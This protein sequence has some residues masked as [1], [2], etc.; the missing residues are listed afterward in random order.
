MTTTSTGEFLVP[1]TPN[2]DGSVSPTP[3]KRER[4]PSVISAGRPPWVDVQMAHRLKIPHTF[5]IHTYTK[6][7]KCH[8]CNKML[9]G[10]FKQGVQCK[11]CRYNA[12]KKCSEKVP[13]DCTGEIPSDYMLD[14]QGDS[15]EYDDHTNGEDDDDDEDDSGSGGGGD[16][17]ED[18]TSAGAA[19]AAA[20]PPP[21]PS[22]IEAAK[23]EQVRIHLSVAQSIQCI[24]SQTQPGPSVAVELFPDEHPCAAF[25][26]VG[27]ADQTHRIQDSQGG[28]ARPLH[29]QGVNEEETL[30]ETRH[31]VHHAVPGNKMP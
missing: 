6:P 31:K 13:R 26:P 24:T 30:L 14:K 7:T 29:Q 23:G 16:S 11:D 21:S 15:T 9:V 3:S 22:V 5:V 17:E 28:L 27:E 19:A 8:F 12:H 20:G 4:T 2:R 10:M 25:G 18:R 1:P